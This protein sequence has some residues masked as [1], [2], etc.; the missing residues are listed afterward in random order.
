MIIAVHLIAFLQRWACS[1]NLL[2]LRVSLLFFPPLSCTTLSQAG[3]HCKSLRWKQE[4]FPPP[5]EKG[6]LLDKWHSTDRHLESRRGLF[7]STQPLAGKRNGWEQWQ[8]CLWSKGRQHGLSEGHSLGRRAEQGF[9]RHCG[10][11]SVGVESPETK[12]AAEANFLL[13]GECRG[14]DGIA[15]FILKPQLMG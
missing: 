1:V 9:I 13:P 3:C 4:A 5:D 12:A 7:I 11:G 14:L 8:A 6:T 15:S 10:G 2:A